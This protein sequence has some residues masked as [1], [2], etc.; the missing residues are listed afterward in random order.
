M[1][2]LEIILVII[3]IV[4]IIFSCFLVDRSKT[5]V[6]SANRN[7]LPQIQN[8]T[9]EE[10]KNIK[11]QINELML[12]ISEDTLNRTDNDLSKLSNEKIMAVNEFS[13]Q[14]LEKINRNHEEVVFLY[15]MLND[16][17]KELKTTVRE[18][19]T[20]KKMVQN[21]TENKNEHQKN[22]ISNMNIT[23]G[24]ESNSKNKKRTNPSSEEK[25]SVTEINNLVA[26][27]NNDKILS[28][29]SKGQTVVEISKQLGLGQG[30]VKL[31][32][33]LYRG[34]K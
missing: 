21:I 11:N 33:D 30:E 29:Y 5:Q 31:V 9:E 8:L 1:N 7:R 34:K 12:K 28:L 14:I 15:N 19:D 13:D 16:K 24:A 23:A 20:S 26:T 17:E 22:Q 18:I 27:N 25:V 10:I 2:P 4:I 6:D 3:G 32:I